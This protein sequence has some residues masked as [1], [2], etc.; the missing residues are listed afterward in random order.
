MEC[1]CSPGST[2]SNKEVDYAALQESVGVGRE[3]T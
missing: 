2:P 3:L 1:Q